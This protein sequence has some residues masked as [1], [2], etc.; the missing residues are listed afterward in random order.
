MTRTGTDFE[1][2]GRRARRLTGPI[3]ERAVVALKLAQVR[4]RIPLV[5]IVAALVVGR[6]ELIRNYWD[7]M[8]GGTLSESTANAISAETEFFCPM[9]PGV[10]SNWP[11]TCGICNMALVRRKRG[12]AIALPDGVVARMQLSPYRIQLAGIQT[13]PVGFQPLVRECETSGIVER[14][15][16]AASVLLEIPARQAPWIAHG[17]AADVQCVD[18]PGHEAMAGRVQ[19]AE[20]RSVD[21]GEYFRITVAVTDASRELRAGMIAVVRV[22]TP[23][24][25]LEPFRS[26]PSDPRRLTADE[27]RTVY[28]CPDHRENLV[29]DDGRCP[30]DKKPREART[31]S[32][33]QRLRWWCPMHPE[34]TADRPGAVC[35]ACGGMVLK[36]RVISYRPAGQ[37]LTVPVSAV[38]DAGARKVVFVET[39]PGMFDGVE[40]VLGPRCGDDY[41][42]VR[43]LEP[44][45]R[46]AF[47]G[48]FLLDAET[49]LNPALASAYFGAGRGKSPQS[50]AGTTKP[51]EPAP[52]TAF[53]ELA[54]DDRVLAE[55]Q[56]LCPVTNKAL[57]SMGTPERVVVL[58]KVVF[59]CCAGCEGAI[60]KEPAKYVAKL[61]PR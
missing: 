15:G 60:T 9:D 47:A 35:K 29:V 13:A 33:L 6:W 41:P 59:L 26:L 24:A 57:G 8:A 17:Q 43:G 55:R 53:A 48:A 20:L 54:P 61:K 50:F 28:A 7:R 51:S 4:L 31:L 37:V 1:P 22:K 56:K 2:A 42:V 39:M 10:I 12:E 36:P 38:V 27:P 16:D 52:S 34:V 44:G 46:V 30:I 14:T 18:L 49:R 11:G 5:L 25:A 58:G 32:D 40:V 19:I 45:Q 3:W 23:M 21:G